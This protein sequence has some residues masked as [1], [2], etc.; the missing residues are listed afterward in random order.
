MKIAKYLILLLLLISGTISV[1][2][3]T[4]DGSYFIQK[5][6]II[7]VSKDLVYKY[8]TDKGNWDSINPWKNDQFKIINQESTDN[9]GVTYQV[10]LN[11]V[12]NELKLELRDT[13]NKKT[14]AIWSTKGKQ[15]FKDK[16][17]S[18]IGR[19]SK[20][21]F[22]DRFEEALS[23]INNTL[24]REINTFDIKVNG[25]VKR[26]T[27]FYIQRPIVSKME[28]IPN[29]IKTN[30][31]Q[32]QQI[33][34]STSTPSNGSPFIVY[35]SKDSVKNKFVYSLA[36]P[37]KHKIYTSPDSDIITGQINPS[38]TIKATLI[39]NYRHKI[40]AIKKLYIFMEDNRLELSDKYKEI[41]VITKSAA[42]DK[43]ASKWIT[44]IYLPVRPKAVIKKASAAK[45]INSDS[46]T[47]A[48]IN[49]VLG[50]DKKQ[51]P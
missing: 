40:E 48:I 9:E 33:L 38:S 26:D 14:V 21:D 4:K 8:V 43:S 25:F 44:E 22:S 29:K 6:K 32:L 2:V 19:G 47:K 15:T 13:L 51:Q 16:L 10:L 11:E 42:T 18:V 39:G 23:S 24:T 20:N 12:E 1:F 50:K 3:A 37:V 49:D 17:L 30:L 46:I 35:H 34:T 45:P 36:I 7:D 28:E 41:E 31:P 27:I 5:S